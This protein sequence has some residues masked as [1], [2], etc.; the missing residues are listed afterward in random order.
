MNTISDE[1]LNKYLDGE[2]SKDESAEVDRIVNG[3]PVW[4]QRLMALKEVDHSLR[5]MPVPEITFDI[6]SMIMQ[7]ILWNEKS[8]RQQKRFIIIVTSI[9]IILCL[10]IIGFVGFELIRN[11][12]PEN[13]KAIAYTI[14]YTKSISELLTSF[15]NKTNMT[16]I[17]AVFSFG[18][19]ISAYFIFDYSKVFRKIGK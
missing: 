5:N 10:S 17:G 11:Y 3:S 2:L 14:K 6:T 7:K 9:F 19:L 16:I 1:I 12:H 18:L 15:F 8:K 13:S 4:K